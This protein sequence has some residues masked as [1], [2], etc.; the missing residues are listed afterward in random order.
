MC[1]RSPF[2][3]DDIANEAKKKL[4]GNLMSDHIVLL[5][6][7]DGWISSENRRMYC[8]EHGLHYEGM[9]TVHDLRKQLGL[10]LA[11][12]GFI[13]RTS[14]KQI[15][16]KHNNSEDERKHYNVLKAAICAGLYPNIVKVKLPEKRYQEVSGGAFW[17][18][19]KSKKKSSCMPEIGA[20]RLMGAAE[21]FYTRQAACLQRGQNLTVFHG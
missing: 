12:A 20:T 5:R 21:C 17:K 10:A 18:R 3:K 13:E 4:G 16:L 19:F 14:M 9:R 6:A 15:V 2:L 8:K 1:T 7:Y 11:D